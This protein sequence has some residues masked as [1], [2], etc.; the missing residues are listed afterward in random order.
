VWT[1]VVDERR[2][3]SLQTDL[4]VDALSQSFML[5][6]G[7]LSVLTKLCLV[8]LSL[9]FGLGLGLGLGSGSAQRKEEWRKMN[10]Q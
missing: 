3:H 5:E 9:G 4:A 10:K 7:M 1:E 6:T 8:P 2:W